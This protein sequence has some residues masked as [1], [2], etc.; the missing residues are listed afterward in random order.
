M[1]CG[2]GVVEERRTWRWTW[3]GGGRGGSGRGGA[4]G[5]W[6]GEDPF[7]LLVGRREID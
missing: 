1:M 7:E 6:T 3:R 5:W 2:A 4:D